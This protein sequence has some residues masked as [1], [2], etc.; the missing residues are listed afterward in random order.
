V[1]AASAAGDSLNN[2]S[3]ILIDE[4]RHVRNDEARMT[5]DE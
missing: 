4:D 5:N 1:K 2:E 3:R